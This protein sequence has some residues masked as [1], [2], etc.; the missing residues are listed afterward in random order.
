ML[1]KRNQTLAGHILTIED[2]IEYLFQNKKSVVNQREVG[3][4][5]ESLQIGAEELPAPGA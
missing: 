1:E 4:D 5:T 3:R 2:P